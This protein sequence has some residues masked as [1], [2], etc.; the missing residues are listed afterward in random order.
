MRIGVFVCHCGSNIAGTVDVAG[1]AKRALSLKDVVHAENIMY[2][3]SE[4]GQAAIQKAIQEKKLDRVVVAACSPHMHEVTFRRCVD[5]GGL[6]PYLFE[7]A[8]IREH[9]SW[10][11]TDMPVATEKAW[12]IIKMSVAKARQL[13]PLWSNEVEVN[14]DVLVIGGGVAGIQ[15]ALDLA[16][17]GLKVTIVERE[18]TIGG[19][20]AK[21]DKTFPTIDCSACILTPRMVDC[22]QHENIDLMAYCE[23]DKVSGYVGNFTVDIRKKASM[24]DWTKCIGC[25]ICVQKCPSKAPDIFNVGLEPTKA[26]YIPFPQAVPKRAAIQVDY[27]RWFTQGKCRVCERVCPADAIDYEQKEEIVQ[28]RF[29]AIVVAT[30]LDVF[31]WEEHYH[32]YGSG[33]IKDVISGLQY[34]RMLNAS[35][36]Y[37]GHVH[38]LSNGEDPK[39]V[40]FIQ[41]VGSRDESVGRPYC[42]SVCCM[43]TAKQALL[44]K[45]HCGMD[46]EVYVFYIDIRAT[47]KGYEEFIKRVQTEFGVKYV[48]GR[49]SKLYEEDGKV[50][51]RGIGHPAGRAGGDRRRPGGAGERH[52]WPPTAPRSW[53][54]SSTSATTSSASSKK[55]IPKLRPVETNTAGV[56]LAGA[57]QAPKDIP[58]TV[59]QASGTASKVIGLLAKDKLKTSPM[60]AVVGQKDC[61]SCWKCIEVCPFSAPEKQEVRP[62]EFKSHVIETVCQGCGVCVATCPVNCISL[63]GFPTDAILDQIEEVLTGHRKAVKMAEATTTQASGAA[64][65]APRPAAGAGRRRGRR[66]S[67]QDH[68]HRLQLVQLRRRRHRRCGPLQAAGQ[69]PAGARALHGPHRPAVRPQGLR[70]GGRR[71]AHQ[72]LPPRRLPLLRRQLLRPAQVRAARAD[73]PPPGHPQG[74]LQ[75][76][77]GLGF[78]RA[79]AGRRWS[80]SSWP[81]WRS[82]ALARGGPCEPARPHPRVRRRCAAATAEWTTSSAGSRATT[83]PRSSR[84]S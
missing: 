26:I 58:A 31:P 12:D 46:T 69:P 54:R 55:A 33:K 15:A 71:R 6:N 45:D 23:V 78:G 28:K 70:E 75:V 84:P 49:V 25:E 43:Y 18:T 63:K 37:G 56:F 7:M 66:P 9:C 32:E 65:R 48:R 29:G 82:S 11:H 19:V 80:P 39:T 20:M 10:I 1:V 4:P 77:L 40:V 81:G 8:N 60:I 73:D 67:G 35:G 42:S 50:M 64:S 59:A 44:T 13:E 52:H 14:K 34:E 36:P 2:T 76:D 16:D 41:C 51:V 30:G 17:A 79:S 24:V 53:P 72:R 38:R 68:R 62:G 74:A 22:A 47:G 21:L 61:V 5:N 3:C 27:C 83:R 57:C